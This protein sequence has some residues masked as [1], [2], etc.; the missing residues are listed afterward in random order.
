FLA[1]AS[2][3]HKLKDAPGGD[4]FLSRDKAQPKRGMIA[5]ADTCARCH[6]SK[7]PGPIV[8][9]SADGCAGPEYVACFEKYWKWTKTDQFR[10]QMREI[11]QADDFLQGNYL[12]SDVRIPVT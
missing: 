8:G 5:F 2:A 1:K 4:K 7:L 10:N 12:S 6:S 3:P 9:L 11:V